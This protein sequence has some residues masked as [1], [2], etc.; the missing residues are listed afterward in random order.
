MSV[1]ATKPIDSIKLTPPNVI[2]PPENRM[3]IKKVLQSNQLTKQLD[4]HARRDNLEFRFSPHINRPRHISQTTIYHISYRMS[5]QLC[6]DVTCKSRVGEDG[7]VW[8]EKVFLCCSLKLL[9]QYA[10]NALTLLI[11][12]FA[13]LLLEVPDLELSFA[14]IRDLIQKVRIRKKNCT[15]GAKRI[16]FIIR[17]GRHKVHFRLCY[18]IE[19]RIEQAYFQA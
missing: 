16:E 11:N 2:T 13:L 17:G 7:L 4:L 3:V 19:S 5:R 6:H 15:Y 12:Q 1:A 8:S 14:D 18:H 10:I 9:R